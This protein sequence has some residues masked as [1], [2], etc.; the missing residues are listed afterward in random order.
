MSWLA[1]WIETTATP[2]SV[3]VAAQEIDDETSEVLAWCCREV[4]PDRH[5]GVDTMQLHY[6]Y[7]IHAARGRGL[8]SM[9]VET[10]LAE[11][12]ALG[13][14]VEPT[15]LSAAGEALLSRARATA[16]EAAQ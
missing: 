3:L 9:L 13:I 4:V 14:E 5:S 6:A 16:K 2:R 8:A 1:R 12:D 7:T 11:A 15:Y 10:V